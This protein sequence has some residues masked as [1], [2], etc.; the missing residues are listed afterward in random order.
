MHAT[1]TPRPAFGPGVPRRDAFPG[2][3]R[4]LA[5]GAFA[6]PLAMGA[7]PLYVHLPR[8]YAEHL[9]IGLA[10]LGALLLAL[11]LADAVVDPLLGAWSDR[12]RSRK[13]L[14]AYAA[15]VL[16]FGMLGLF[17]PL[18]RG[19]VPLLAWLGVS[20]A[21]VYVAF[22]LATINHNAW[23]A[24]LS[25]DP[26]ERTRITATREGL[27]LAGVVVASVAPALLGGAGGEAEGLP[28]FAFAYAAIVAAAL[29]VTLAAPS[30][31]E[32]PEPRGPW[33]GGLGE[34]WRDT[35]FRR[36]LAIFVANGIA[37]A[38]PATLVLF[39]IADVLR[40]EGSQGWLLVLY[41]GAGAAGLPLWTRL[42]ARI[43]KDAAWGVSMAVA[44]VAFAGA[45]ALGPGDAAAFAMI[46]A[47]SGVALG[48]DL[49]LPPSILADVI[50]RRGAMRAA[51]AYFGVWTLATKA[52]LALAAGV[53]LPLLDALGYA[54]GSRDPDAMRALA[55]VYAGVPCV[56]K[57]LALVAL[58]VHARRSRARAAA[59]SG[60]A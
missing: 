4:R 57:A 48:A 32:I 40:A 13:R 39:F 11:R 41:F 18:V 21:F 54:P 56:L 47:L 26:V 16:A 49:A 10:S 1:D 55:I 28:R 38:I 30:G 51:G 7:L 22:S 45:A 15:P 27:A 6:V 29:A 20:L 46:C 52:N 37:S 24:E 35:M 42:S 8:F 60:I 12:L 23:G 33:L 2:A 17:N 43:G 53:A 36:L 58:V 44:I 59:P 5:Y 19:E 50:G 9:G 3:A 14:I 25:T 34:A 31:P